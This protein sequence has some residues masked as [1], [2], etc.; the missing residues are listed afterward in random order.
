MNYRDFLY[1]AKGLGVSAV[2]L[3][4]AA[5]ADFAEW[6]RKEWADSLASYAEPK[7]HVARLLTA[8]RED[9]VANLLLGGVTFAGVSFRLQ[10]GFPTCLTPTN[11]AGVGA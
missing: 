3:K 1:Q 8:T 7:P 11:L 9:I 5:Y 10:S 2:V 4:P 6:W